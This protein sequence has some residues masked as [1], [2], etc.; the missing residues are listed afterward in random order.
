MD[1]DYD[2]FYATEIAERKEL[3]YPPFSHLARLILSTRGRGWQK[4]GEERL[5]SLLHQFEVEI[6]GPA[7]H[8]TRRECQ[9]LLLKGITR[10]TVR[11]ACAAVQQGFPRI[12]ID[13]DPERI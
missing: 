4:D 2:R 7:P 11:E 1:G 10:E 6:L 12:E 3:F 13:I 9:V 8:P 5:L